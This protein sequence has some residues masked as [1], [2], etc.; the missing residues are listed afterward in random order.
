MHENEYNLTYKAKVED[1]ILNKSKI[2][3]GVFQTSAAFDNNQG[4]DWAKKTHKERINGTLKNAGMKRNTLQ[5]TG[6]TFI[7]GANRYDQLLTDFGEMPRLSILNNY[8][9]IK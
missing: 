3:H 7:Q 2:L 4:P 1:H 9:R 8:K 6:D 5:T